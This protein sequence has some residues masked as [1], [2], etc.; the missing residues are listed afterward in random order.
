[1]GSCGSSED[2]KKQGRKQQKNIVQYPGKATGAS[3]PN[4]PAPR[5]SNAN[6][7]KVDNVQ[8]G[9]NPPP[10]HSRGSTSTTLDLPVHNF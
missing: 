3:P 6:N 5:Q 2:K 9:R 4:Q 1:M 7:A 10:V 8:S